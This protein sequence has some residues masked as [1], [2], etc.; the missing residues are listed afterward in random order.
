[1]LFAQ[2]AC[3]LAACALGLACLSAASATASTHRHH[4]LDRSGRTQHGVASYYGPGL[5]GK[6]TASG[7]TF[8]PNR[9]TAA[10][11]T[12]PLGAKARVVNK[13]TGK[14][15]D[16]TVTDRGP[17]TRHRVLDVSPKAARALG[18][19]HDGTAPVKVQ[20]LKLPPA[21]K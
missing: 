20:P 21:K 4:H 9:L 5:A 7:R 1:M 12:L 3:R 11:R 19:T 17:Y 8:K 16:V 10:S 15:V 6:K 2:R 18:M 13:E 14:S